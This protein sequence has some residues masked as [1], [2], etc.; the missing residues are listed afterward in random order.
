[1]KKRKI[2]LIAMLLIGIAYMAMFFMT[3]E[4]DNIISDSICFVMTMISVVFIV[5]GILGLVFKTSEEHFEDEREKNTEA[6][7]IQKYYRCK[8]YVTYVLIAINV[9]VFIMVKSSEADDIVLTYAVSKIDFKVWKL[10]TSMFMHVDETHILLNMLALWSVRNLEEL[11][12]NVKYLLCYMLSGIGASLLIALF[13]DLP[14]V[15][16]SGAI[17][18]LFG[19]YLLITFKNRKQMKY[20]F[21]KNLL[22]TVV[23]ELIITIIMPNVSVIAHF[24]GLIIGMLC[25]FLFCRKVT[26]ENLLISD[27]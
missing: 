21:W 14:C 1:M 11:I 9:L 18:G 15:G 23:I 27:E 10:L 12:G 4:F 7:R 16:A 6:V 5:L 25:Y 2:I 13:S 22:P 3:D 20:T 26:L 17:L 8:P 19:C 24:G